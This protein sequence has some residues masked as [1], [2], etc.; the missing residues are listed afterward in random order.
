MERSIIEAKQA[1]IASMKSYF[2]AHPG[3][4]SAVRQPLLFRFDNVWTASL[5]SNLR[6]AIAGVGP[7]VEAALSDFDAQY[8]RVLQSRE[9]SSKNQRAQ[10]NEAIMVQ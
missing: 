8:L 3:S 1:A 2:A 7:T 6:E 9:V 4:P 5:V 10:K